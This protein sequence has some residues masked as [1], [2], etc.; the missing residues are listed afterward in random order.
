MLTA[1]LLLKDIVTLKGQLT[2]L[3][4]CVE[5]NQNA[6]QTYMSML[7]DDNEIL[8]EF[9]LCGKNQLSK[10]MVKALTVALKCNSVLKV[11]CVPGTYYSSNSV[12]KIKLDLENENRK[13]EVSTKHRK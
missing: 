9:E 5:G 7:L 4:F 6:F 1:V 2:R 13:V 10:D 3:K 12:K 11:L 8:E